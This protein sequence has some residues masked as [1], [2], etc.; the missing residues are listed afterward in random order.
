MWGLAPLQNLT[1]AAKYEK[2][3]HPLKMKIPYVD[4]W[5][6][7]ELVSPAKFPEKLRTDDFYLGDFGLAMKINEPVAQQGR[8][9]QQFCS[10]ERLHGK[11][12]SFACDMW[13]YIMI[14]TRLYLGFIPFQVPINGGVLRTLV[15]CLGPL[16]RE[17]KGLIED[18]EEY[19]YWYDQETKPEP[20]RE[21]ATILARYSNDPVERG[22]MHS[23]MSKVLTFYPEKRPSAE[24]LLHDPSFRAIMEKYGC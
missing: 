16:P 1:R 20:G 11:G 10:P 22:H 23:I 9:P 24:Q 8:P 21:L 5:K 4:L 2:L 15:S 7:G 13:S 14:F 17:W 19:N 12:P 3:G 6:Q 18:T